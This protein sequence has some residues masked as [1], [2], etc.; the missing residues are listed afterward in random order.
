MA[1]VMIDPLTDKLQDFGWALKQLWNGSKVAR[2][3]WNGGRGMW[4]N[5]QLPDANSKMTMP[6][7]YMKTVNGGLVPWLASQS[8][9]LSTDWETVA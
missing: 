3:G 5:L 4:I 6:Y 2:H 9:L 7:I 8:D 1:E